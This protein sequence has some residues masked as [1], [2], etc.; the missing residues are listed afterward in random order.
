MQEKEIQKYIY[1]Y[2]RYR[3]RSNETEKQNKINI[4][5]KY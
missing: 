5:D 4:V 3:S 2:G 1:R